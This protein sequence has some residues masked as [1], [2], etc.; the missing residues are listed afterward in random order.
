[1][2]VPSW[3]TASSPTVL[4]IRGRMMLNVIAPSAMPMRNS[5][6]IIVNT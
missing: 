6:R 1:M 4:R 2:A 5:A 3:A